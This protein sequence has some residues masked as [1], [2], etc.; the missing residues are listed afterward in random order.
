ME[1]IPESSQNMSFNR[2]S[3]CSMTQRTDCSLSVWLTPKLKT[4]PW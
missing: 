4:K 2:T 1:Q 3:Q